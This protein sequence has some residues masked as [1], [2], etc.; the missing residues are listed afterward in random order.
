M[1]THVL[2][3][4]RD[5]EPAGPDTPRLV[6]ATDG[7]ASKGQ[8]G[9]GYNVCRTTRSQLEADTDSAQTV[10][11]AVTQEAGRVI[12]DP[13]RP[14][15]IGAAKHTNNTGELSAVYHALTRAPSL[16]RPGEELVIMPDSQLAICTTTGAWASKKHT[17]LVRRNRAAFAKLREQGTTVR[18]QHVRAHRGHAMNEAAD[19]LA[20]KGAAGLRERD[21]S[22]YIP[23]R[24]SHTTTAPPPPLPL[25]P[26]PHRLPVDVVPD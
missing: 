25:P 9:W 22:L 5:P 26:L 16:L 8:A 7:F 14:E 1:Q 15:Y 4:W 2:A 17:E 18:F 11:A 13:K 23:S 21:G 3:N 24:R 20:K 19:E 12:T 10:A 6:I